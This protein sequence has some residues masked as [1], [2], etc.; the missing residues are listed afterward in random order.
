MSIRRQYPLQTEFSIDKLYTFHYYELAKSF[1]TLGEKHDFWELVYVDKGETEL[2]TDT[3]R[4]RL[5]QGDL[6]LLYP[7]QFH[8]VRA[9]DAIVLMIVSFE[10]RSALLAHFHNRVMKLAK[11][12]H[13]ILTQLLRE[14]FEAFDPPISTLFHPYLG[15]KAD[16]PFGSEHLIKNYLEILLIMLVRRYRDR[17]EEEDGALAVAPSENRKAALLVRVIDYMN[18][19][20]SRSLKLEQVCGEFLIG[21]TQLKSLFKEWT[22]H[23][24]IQYFNQLKIQK[25]KTMIR[26]ELYNYSEIADRLGYNS[27]H[28][29]SASFK[30]ATGMT[31]TEYARTVQARITNRR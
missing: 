11:E 22:G 16:S 12:E 14:G 20:L 10:S 19:N 21:K 5:S 15:K 13:P 29:F 9:H 1:S 17:Q 3:G 6:F 2:F 24:P 23:G 7:N 27:V 31:P 18:G 4:F 26:E 8:G 28:Y 25:A 30:K